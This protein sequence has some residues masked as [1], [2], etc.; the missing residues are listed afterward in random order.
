[1]IGHLGPRRSPDRLADQPREG[2]SRDIGTSGAPGR[3]IALASVL[4]GA[5]GC[6]ALWGSSDFSFDGNGGTGAAASGGSS[7]TGAGGNGSGAD[8]SG[9]DGSGGGNTGANTSGG[10]GGIPG[11]GG[12]GPCMADDDCPL[13][14]IC[15]GGGCEPGC[16]AAHA[17][18]GMLSCCNDAC[19]DTDSD[20]A[21]CSSC[22]SP[23]TGADFCVGGSCEGGGNAVTVSFSP[24]DD[25]YVNSSSINAN[26]V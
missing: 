3:A 25:T 4:L 26:A 1:M 21:H 8:G 23:C 6:N 10:A 24:S 2:Q 22:N 11:T 16:T 17:C 18:A 9:A 14:T 5:T 15:S 12:A 19:V 20:E 13:G 7:N